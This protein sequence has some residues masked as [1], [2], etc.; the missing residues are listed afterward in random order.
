[1]QNKLLRRGRRLN[2]QEQIQRKQMIRD[3]IA[4]L[5]RVF[6]IVNVE[7]EIEIK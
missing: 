3:D 7:N 5:E 4:Y 2:A 6:D 1:M